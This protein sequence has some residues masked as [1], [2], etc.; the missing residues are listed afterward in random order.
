ML[1]QACSR[2]DERY[3]GLKSLS[4]LA[5]FFQYDQ[6]RAIGSKVLY[7]DIDIRAKPDM[8]SSLWGASKYHIQFFR[9][10]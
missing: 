6:V 7:I 2:L 3:S 1:F 9:V 8:N 5:A 10:G 4:R